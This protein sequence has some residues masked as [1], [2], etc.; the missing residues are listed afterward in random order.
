MDWATILAAFI[1]GLVVGSAIQAYI[2]YHEIPRRM[3]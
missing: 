1:L 3:R 2:I